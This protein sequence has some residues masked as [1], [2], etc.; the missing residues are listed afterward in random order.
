MTAEKLASLFFSG[1]LTETECRL[2]TRFMLFGWD[3]VMYQYKLKYHNCE[4]NSQEE[5]NKDYEY[6]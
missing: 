2:V 1:A 5:G 3:D 4:R 6:L